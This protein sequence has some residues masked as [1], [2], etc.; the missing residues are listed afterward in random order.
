MYRVVFFVL[1]WNS[2]SMCECDA[3]MAFNSNGTLS[4]L[5]V[6]SHS[7]FALVYLPWKVKALKLCGR[8]ISCP[9][10]LVY[11]GNYSCRNVRQLT[12][13]GPPPHT[14][15]YTHLYDFIQLNQ[16][17]LTN[18]A[19]IYSRFVSLPFYHISFH[20][21]CHCA[22]FLCFPL[23]LFVIA[24]LFRRLFLLFFLFDGNSSGHK[25]L[26]KRFSIGFMCLLLSQFSQWSHRFV[27]K[28]HCIRNTA[29]E[30][31][32]HKIE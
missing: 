14:H 29:T 9:F 30:R 6:W 27:S 24:Y 12:A 32:S 8:C 7:W 4:H 25:R 11:I 1:V 19:H 21:I 20:S 17:E 5:N 10:S 31:L 23:N 13:P 16:S 28:C 2:T 3:H 22:V 15:T 18:A 26:A